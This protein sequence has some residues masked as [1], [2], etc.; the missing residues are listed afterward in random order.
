MSLTPPPPEH[1]DPPAGLRVQPTPADDG[2]AQERGLVKVTV[3][4]TPAI[5]AALERAAEAMDDSRTDTINRAISLYDK[6]VAGAAELSIKLTVPVT[7]YRRRPWLERLLPPYRCRVRV[8]A[9][10]P[11]AS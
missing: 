5:F 3:Y 2:E 8:S 1:V 6:V 10:E 4:L 7:M 11:S 9:P